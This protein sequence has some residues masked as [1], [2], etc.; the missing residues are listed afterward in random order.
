MDFDRLLLWMEPFVDRDFIP[1]PFDA[2]VAAE[3]LAAAGRSETVH[4]RLLQRWNGFYALGHLLHVFSACASPPNQSLLGW[5]ADN[6]WRGSWGLST[7]GLTFFA[8]DAFGDQFAYR[9]GK[10]VRL[11]TIIGG[12]EA[13]QTTLEEWIEAVLLEPEYI[14]NRRLFDA[15]VTRHGPLPAGGHFVPTV[16]LAVGDSIDPDRVQ[17]VPAR[18]SM[19][20]KAVTAARIVRRTSQSMRIPKS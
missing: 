6:G 17:I 8:E 13:M 16:P 7:E 20:M 12:I 10:V 18:D 2:A 9:A 11:R 15:C 14:L 4:T 5:N 19:E 3:V 1:P